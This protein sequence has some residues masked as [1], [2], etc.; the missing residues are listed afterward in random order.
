MAIFETRGTDSMRHHYIPQ[1]LLRAWAETQPDRKVQTFRLDLPHLPSS[2]HAP[3]HIAYEENLY[4]LTMPAV[5]GMERQAVEKYLL[6]RIDN[7]AAGV[8]RDL[9]ATGL[10][11]LTPEDRCD[12]ARF[13][14][15]LRLRQPHIVQQ[16]RIASSE[17]LEA[18]L[19]ERPEEYDA[20]A[21][22]GDPPILLQ[23]T[24]EKYPGL[25]E[26][27][28]MSFFHKLV[29]NK[30]VGGKILRMK[31]WLW[32]FSSEQHDLLLADQPCIFTKGIDNPDLVI[33]LPI[34]PSKAFMATRTE[35]VAT[36]LRAQRPKD[37]LMRMN[38]SSLN[39]ARVR[40]YARDASPRRFI[41]NR[42]AERRATKRHD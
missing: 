35:R 8:L 23:W 6:R 32:D 18:S 34:G 31:W 26:N 14:M 22:A 38:E 3:K 5:A 9:T 24:R 40:V 7:L 4:A 10:S 41:C 17:H 28:G 39:Q 20:V 27:F 2:R 1:F 30:E 16:L 13:L 21:E 25:I 42:L 15:S 33:A 19:A 36:L 37:L 11:C 29:D 12:W